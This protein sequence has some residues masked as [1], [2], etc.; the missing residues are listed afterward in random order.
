MRTRTSVIGVA[1]MAV[2]LLLLPARPALAHHAPDVGPVW[3]DL[4]PSFSFTPSVPS[5]D[6]RNRITDGMRQWNDVGTSLQYAG[7]TADSPDRDPTDTR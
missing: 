4:T 7:P 1:A 2:L 3:G 6:W 5:S